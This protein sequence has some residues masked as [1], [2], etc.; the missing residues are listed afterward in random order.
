MVASELPTLA[1]NTVLHPVRRLKSPAFPIEPLLILG[2]RRAGNIAVVGIG[3]KPRRPR[4][5][6]VEI[7]ATFLKEKA[8]EIRPHV[9]PEKALIPTERL[10][11]GQSKNAATRVERTK[12]LFEKDDAS[13][14]AHPDEFMRVVRAY[15]EEKG[16]HERWVA[17]CAWLWLTNGRTDAALMNDFGNCGGRG[18]KRGFSNKVPGPKQQDG[19]AFDAIS[20]RPYTLAQRIQLTEVAE[21]LWKK[22][23]KFLDLYWKALRAEA[24]KLALEPPSFEQAYYLLEGYRARKLE[25]QTTGQAHVRYRH[26]TYASQV[27][28]SD[29]TELQMFTRSELAENVRL[30]NPVLY[31]I[32]DVKWNYIA[33]ILVSYESPSNALVAELLYRAVG[34]MVDRCR[35]LGLPYSEIDLP[36][37]HPGKELWFDHQELTAP[38][39]KTALL[40]HFDWDVRFAMVGEGVDKGA[41]EGSIGH[42]KRLVSRGRD[43]FPK[44]S[45]GKAL[46]RARRA[47]TRDIQTLEAELIREM[48]ATNN[49][50]L[51]ASRVPK[52]FLATGL[53]ATRVEL[54]KWDLVRHRELVK[55]K[56]DKDAL[57]TI[58]LPTAWYSV[59]A[60][61]GIYIRGRYYYSPEL[62]RAGLLQYRSKGQKREV[63]VAEHRGT[64]AFVFW[65]KPDGDR[66]RCNLRPTQMDVFGHMDVREADDH[67]KSMPPVRK[68]QR[69][70]DALSAAQKS[71]P[72]TPQARRRSSDA[73]RIGHVTRDR[74]EMHDIR[75]AE[76]SLNAKRD[77]HRRFPND[78]PPPDT[79]H[80]TRRPSK[81]AVAFDAEQADL[82]ASMLDERQQTDN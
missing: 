2:P 67:I 6:S 64:A 76:I 29:S 75:K 42:T 32:I 81:T 58:C 49:R 39:L 38:K 52:A 35:E 62:A 59:H 60:N 10:K 46:E 66:V 55:P 11:P 63:E 40:R 19:S 74:Q 7:V 20:G 24:I 43:A 53:P 77:A 14:L 71:V 65:V 21:K 27:S 25:K 80:L 56:P 36:S 82:V 4:W 54:Y 12:E 44:H 61:Q 8:I 73:A 16:L 23:P 28:E 68:R 22:G 57:A 34:G 45:V 9:Y 13:K 79:S 18:K 3:K 48:H 31:K 5:M 47:T 1:G 50:E 78:V 30:K 26:V 33:A 51:P 15:A 69:L 17:N 41:I 70:K 72:Q 37:L